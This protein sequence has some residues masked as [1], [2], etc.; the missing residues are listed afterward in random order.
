MSTAFDSPA[1]D[2]SVGPV[3]FQNDRAVDVPDSG[4]GPELRRMRCELDQEPWSARK[5]QQILLAPA[6]DCSCIILVFASLCRC[7]IFGTNADPKKK[8]S[9]DG[10]RGLPKYDRYL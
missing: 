10:R 3:K 4:A 8:K 2:L 6:L 9:H 5:P 1:R 7:T